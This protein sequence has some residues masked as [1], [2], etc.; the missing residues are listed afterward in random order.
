MRRALLWL[1]ILALLGGCNYIDNLTGLSKES[2]KAMGASCRQTGRSLEECFRRNPEADKAQLYSGWREMHEYMNKHKLE[3]M[4]PPPE[5]VASA[6]V[7]AK[8][9]S[10]PD[11]KKPEEEGHKPASSQTGNLIQP[12]APLTDEAADQAVQN[13]PQVEAVLATIRGN[14]SAAAPKVQQ[15]SADEA[16]Q[17]KLLDLIKQ[18][19]QNKPAS[20]KAS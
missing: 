12:P 16:E 9:G 1:P 3:T 20:A 19:N 10:K 11:E 18:L 15:P 17:K 4:A 14:K 6:A 8:P 5:P 2:H 7:A 13:D